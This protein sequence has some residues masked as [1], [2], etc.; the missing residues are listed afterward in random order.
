[1]SVDTLRQLTAQLTERDR[2]VLRLLCDHSVLS[3][4]QIQDLG[5]PGTRITERRLRTL[6][7]LRAVD[8]VRLP[9]QFEYLWML[10]NSGAE[11]IAAER[12]IDVDQLGWTHDRVLR[13][14]LHGQR[15]DHLLGVNGFF[16]AL[17]RT[18]ERSGGRSALSEWWPERRCIEAWG[19]WVKP[20]AFG[21]WTEGGATTRFLL[22]Y[23]CGT[24][25]GPRLLAKLPGYERLAIATRGAAAWWLLFRFH[26]ERRE[27]SVR[28]TLAN[29]TAMSN[30]AT[31][32]LV[33]G[34][35]PADRVWA[36][37]RSEAR[38]TLRELTA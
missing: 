8:R 16:T 6:Y 7:L 29:A 23:D 9:G 3:T 32:S 12:E 4:S 25:S 36:P 2:R 33:P 13:M 10:H 11:V 21:E 27:R 5:F 14:I 20:D 24:E 1:V 37:L 38:R 35:S 26:S 30:L 17:L 28:P 15:R 22:E 34:A 19:R 18:A 31:A